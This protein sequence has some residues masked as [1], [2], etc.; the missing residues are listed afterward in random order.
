MSNEC[1]IILIL[2]VLKHYF[3]CTPET[4]RMLLSTFYGRK[5]DVVGEQPIRLLVKAM[6]SIT[7]GQPVSMGERV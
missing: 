7:K 1:P 3:V 2:V 6:V 4:L 5:C